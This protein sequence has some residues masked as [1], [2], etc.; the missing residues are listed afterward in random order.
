M[1]NN[2]HKKP[3]LIWD[4][5]YRTWSD[6]KKT[7][8]GF[9]S[10]KWLK[11]IIKQ[12]DDYLIEIK[13]FGNEAIPPRPS[14]LPMLFS[15]L[16]PESVIDFGGSN[17]W[18]WYYLKQ[19]IPNISLKKYRIIENQLINNYYTHSKFHVD[20]PI[21]YSS[22]VITNETYELFYSNSAIQYLNNDDVLLKL[23]KDIKPKYILFDDFLGGDFDDYYSSQIYYNNYIPVRFR[24]EKSFL[25]NM[26][27]MSFKLIMKSDYLTKIKGRV[28][29]LPMQNIPKKR[30][31]RF[32]KTLLFELNS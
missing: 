14:S 3:D 23:I 22:N 24:N 15:V 17:G 12:L 1:E 29:E 2:L 7:G 13:K 27:D 32:A 11:S 30:R 28:G 31:V 21:Q 25:N 26:S 16:N 18:T 6:A 19:C 20:Q 4:G 8:E 9:K 5:V 10:D